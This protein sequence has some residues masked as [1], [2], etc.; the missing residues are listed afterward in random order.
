V[1]GFHLLT[2]SRLHFGLIDPTGVRGRRFGGVGM[3]VEE[4][5]VEVEVRDASAFHCRS[6]LP[7]LA[8]RARHVIASVASATRTS[9]ACTVEVHRSPDEH[10]GLGTGTQLDL[11]LA[12]AFARLRGID[13]GLEELAA[14]AGRG[15]RSAI[16]FHGFQRG[17]FL[18]D[19]GKG[20]GDI[21]APLI[22]RLEVPRDWRVVLVTPRDTKGLW[23]REETQ[24]FDE[25]EPGRGE[26]VDALCR[27]VLLGL[28]PALAD[29]DLAAFGEALHELGLRAGAPFRR[30][31]H[32][33]FA[34]AM[35]AD[36]VAHLRSSGIS[37]A[38]QSSWGPTLYAIAGDPEE[39]AAAAARVRDRFGFRPGEV[40]ITAARN[41]GASWAANRDEAVDRSQA[42]REDA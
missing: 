29:G 22:A 42:S 11:A 23:G 9:A 7:P 2:G 32:G 30:W 1:S 20:P 27:L 40:R 10:L 18:V 5:A 39:A 35:A 31:Q 13:L 26:D 34:S 16:G 33:A 24:S 37:G 6:L 15:R 8:I 17:G 36:V 28:L 3:M 25:L 14:I 38:G 21:I 41:C 12:S 19:G 4:P